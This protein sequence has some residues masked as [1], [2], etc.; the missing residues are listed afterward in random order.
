MQT[1]TTPIFFRVAIPVV[2]PR[3]RRRL[4]VSGG[5]EDLTTGMARD[6]MG[7]ISGE[8]AANHECLL[9][10]RC[11]RGDLNRSSSPH[12]AFLR[13]RRRA[14]QISTDRVSD[15]ALIR[16][17]RRGA[18]RAGLEGGQGHTCRTLR[19]SRAGVSMPSPDI[20]AMTRGHVTS[21]N[22]RS[23]TRSSPASGWFA[24]SVTV[25]SETSITETIT[26]SAPG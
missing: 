12:R 11:R 25:D 10:N 7:T 18:C 24:S 17:L 26:G 8:P 13:I 1:R 22:S 23:K 19:Q 3:R 5:R 9:E 6:Y 20:L 2:R 15:A 14:F 16:H 21:T 4:A